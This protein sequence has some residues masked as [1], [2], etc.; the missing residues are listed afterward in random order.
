[1][2]YEESEHKLSERTEKYEK[3]VKQLISDY[4]GLKEE[5][6]ELNKKYKKLLLS[7]ENL[8]TEHE[9]LMTKYENAINEKDEKLSSQK[10]L[11]AKYKERDITQVQIKKVN[12]EDIFRMKPKKTKGSYINVEHLKCE[13]QECNATNVDLIKCNVCSKWICEECNDVPVNKLKPI[14]NK[15]KTLYF[16]CKGCDDDIHSETSTSKDSSYFSEKEQ[17]QMKQGEVTESIKYFEA[18]L[19][20]KIM[21]LGSKL[22][23]LI[24]EKLNTLIMP[25]NINNEPKVTTTVIKDDKTYS[26]ML[27]RSKREPNL[28][29]ILQETRNEEKAEEREQE[30]RSK[31]VI[32]HGL[33][34][35]G[36]HN[37]EI[38]YNDKIIIFSILEKVGVATQPESIIRLGKPGENKKRTLKIAMTAIEEKENFMQNLNRL[39]GS[40]NEFGKISVTADYT[41]RERDLIKIWI[42]K[43]EEK[44]RDD[45]EKFYRVRGDPKQGLRLV[46]FARVN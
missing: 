38:K 1:M 30:R 5:F 39:K 41:T 17:T 11:I 10:K 42:Q 33:E 45:S 6:D 15:C 2:S 34:E 37:D 27:K 46:S 28:K 8:K 24:D 4:D 36:E 26:E 40:E 9:V 44:S 32:I 25:N 43:A 35:R 19:D 13:F 18:T 29:Q 23:T 7:K 21:K 3:K 20:K 31:N 16:I 14:Y 12:N 22:E